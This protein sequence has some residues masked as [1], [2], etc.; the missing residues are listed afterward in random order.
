MINENLAR[1]SNYAIYGAMVVYFIA[2]LAYTAEWVFGRK[3]GFVVAAAE[4][5]AAGAAKVPAQ[6]KTRCCHK[7]RQAGPM[8]PASSCREPT[9]LS[10]IAKYSCTRGGWR[11]RRPRAVCRRPQIDGHITSN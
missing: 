1:F 9:D 8:P 2:F 6:G 3:S 7:P 5:S 10:T 4:Q 11:F